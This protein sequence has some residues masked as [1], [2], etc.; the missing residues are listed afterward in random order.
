MSLS[1]LIYGALL[2]A[3]LLFSQEHETPAAGPVLFTLEETREQVARAMGSPDLVANFGTDLL[4][5][6]F[7]LGGVDH[8][9]GGCTAGEYSHQLVFRKSTGKL[10]SV[11]VNFEHDQ[12]VDALF[13]EDETAVHHYPDAARPQ[14][15]VALRRLPGGR[16]LIATGMPEPGRSAAQLLL[17][18][19]SEIR[20]FLPWLYGRLQP[21][22][23]R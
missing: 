16:A 10:V 23:T 8:H 12:K 7:R 17:I 15:S 18:R 9:S 3:A 14:L 1:H 2:S 5:W 19:E 13:P 11:T 22:E 6:Q 20:H 4:S 21:G